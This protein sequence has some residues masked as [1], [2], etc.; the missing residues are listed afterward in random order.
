MQLSDLDV[1]Q[2]YSIDTRSLQRGDVFIALHGP[3]FDGHDYLA[4]AAEKGAS[5][6]IVEREVTTTLPLIIVDDSFATFC[7]LAKERRQALSIPISAITGSCG[8]TTTKTMLANILN[9]VGETLATEKNFNNNIGVPLTLLK[10]MPEH[11]FTV[12]EIGA[13]MKH[14]IAFAAEI[15]SPDIA[16]ITNAAPVHL[17][18]FGNLDS[19]AR[20]KGD[21]LTNLQPDGRG[22]LNADDQYYAYWQERLNGREFISFGL[23]NKADV[24]AKDIAIDADDASQFSL[25]TPQDSVDVHLRLLGEHNIYNALAAAAAALAIGVPLQLIKIGLENVTAVPNRMI[26]KVGKNGVI[27]IDDSYNANPRSMQAAMRILALSSGKKVMVVG[28][29]GELGADA[30]DFHRQLGEE[31]RAIGVDYLFAVG[32]LTRLTVE[33]FG[34]NAEFF[35][36]REELIAVLNK[37]AQQGV[38]VLVK[39]SKVNRLWEIVA[40]LL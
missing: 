32:D 1:F 19:V 38:T 33:A 16:I 6:A 29:M 14:E 10:I 21:I 30:R 8:K 27:I 39:G 15:A 35:S 36:E 31:A 7:D 40:S 22:I 17:E 5:A 9:G 18:G 12:I 2:T 4:M 28:D 3:N 11:K 24:M 20:I 34:N 26:K 37:M 13:N 25:V 23:H